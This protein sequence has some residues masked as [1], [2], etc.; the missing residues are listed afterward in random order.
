MG[1]E[2]FLQDG[3]MYE[4]ILPNTDLKFEVKANAVKDYLIIKSKNGRNTYSYKLQVENLKSNQ[5]FCSSLPYRAH[6]FLF[7]FAPH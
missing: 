2:L 4:D 3:L 5:A 7:K 1:E 6:S